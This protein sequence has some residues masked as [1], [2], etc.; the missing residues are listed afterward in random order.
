[1]IINWPCERATWENVL[2]CGIRHYNTLKRKYPK[3]NVQY[4]SWCDDDKFYYW[5]KKSGMRCVFIDKPGVYGFDWD[6]YPYL[7]RI[8]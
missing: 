7:T 1:M 8:R 6:N 2:V 3:R 4:S 5:N